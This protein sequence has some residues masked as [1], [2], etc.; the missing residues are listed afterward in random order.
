MSLRYCFA[1]VLESLIDCFG[2]ADG[3]YNFR[4]NVRTL[5][6]SQHANAILSGCLRLESGSILIGF[7]MEKLGS[8]LLGLTDLMTALVWRANEVETFFP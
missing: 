2:M 6:S 7:H 8:Q 5:K 4:L 1:F 3:W